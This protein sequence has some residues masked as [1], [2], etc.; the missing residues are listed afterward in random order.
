AGTTRYSHCI[1][2]SPRVGRECIECRRPLLDEDLEL[3][4][5][6]DAHPELFS[7]RELGACAGPRGDEVRL[8]RDARRGLSARGDDRLLCA[9]ARVALEA[10][11]EEHTSELQS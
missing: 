3:R 1:R 8:L 10:R 4:R 2:E 5:I 6:D 9:F 7:L 11:S